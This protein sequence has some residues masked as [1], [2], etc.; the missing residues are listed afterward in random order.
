MCWNSVGV[1]EE[2]IHRPHTTHGHAGTHTHAAQQQQQQQP[3]HHASG[4]NGRNATA[5][6]A[7]VTNRIHTRTRR[8][9][10]TLC[11]RTLGAL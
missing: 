6:L 10:H 1:W 7:Y 9:K 3:H 11:E 5:V 2:T 4:D 8:K